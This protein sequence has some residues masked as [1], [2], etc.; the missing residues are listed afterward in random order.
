MLFASLG[1]SLPDSANV[2]TSPIYSSQSSSSSSRNETGSL[3]S[4]DVDKLTNVNKYKQKERDKYDIYSKES[5][6]VAS[7]SIITQGIDKDPQV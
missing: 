6:V 3:V 7:T 4:L 1:S 2:F 5:G